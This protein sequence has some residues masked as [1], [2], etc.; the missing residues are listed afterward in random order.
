MCRH[1]V[2][3]LPFCASCDALEKLLN[4]HKSDFLNLNT[5]EVVNISGIDNNF[6]NTGAV[7]A[8]IESIEKECRNSITLTVK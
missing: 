6:H 7:I 2:F 4:D 3:V 1:M 5:Y 8:K